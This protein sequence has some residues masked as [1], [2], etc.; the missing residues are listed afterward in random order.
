MQLMVLELISGVVTGAIRHVYDS[1]KKAW[2]EAESIKE[3]EH[4][5]SPMAV[6]EPSYRKRTI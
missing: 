3:A 1:I 6:K 5:F 4:V 2:T